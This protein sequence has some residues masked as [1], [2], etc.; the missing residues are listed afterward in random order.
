MQSYRV[1]VLIEYTCVLVL[2]EYRRDLL[3][4][5]LTNEQSCLLIL[6]MFEKSTTESTEKEFRYTVSSCFLSR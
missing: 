2:I 5:V 4:L 3:L 6:P 1:L